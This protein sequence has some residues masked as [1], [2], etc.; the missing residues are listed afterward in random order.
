MKKGLEQDFRDLV[1]IYLKKYDRKSAGENIKEF[2]SK[3]GFSCL[4]D[5]AKAIQ[6]QE[7]FQYISSHYREKTTD[8]IDSI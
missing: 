3:I 6:K 8:I 4:S 5:Q 2:D 7:I 1:F